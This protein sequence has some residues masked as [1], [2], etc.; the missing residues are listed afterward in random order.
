[1]SGNRSGTAEDRQVL[2]KVGAPS[3]RVAVDEADDVDAVLRMLD[4]LA[5]DQLA[6]LAGADDQRV[7][8]VGLSPLAGTAGDRARERQDADRERTRT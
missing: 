4:E 7:L 2:G 8:L 6:D 1:M 3:L 5:G